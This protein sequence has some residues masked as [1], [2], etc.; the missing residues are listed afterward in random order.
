MFRIRFRSQD[1]PDR[2]ESMSPHHPKGGQART[3]I[4]MDD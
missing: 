4:G 2:C 3:E 1:D